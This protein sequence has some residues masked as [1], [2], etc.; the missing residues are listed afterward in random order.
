MTDPHHD[1]PIEESLDKE[2]SL[3]GLWIFGL[4]ILALI[5]AA[6]AVTWVVSVS[7]RSHLEAQDPPTP[8][9]IE[10]RWEHE[11]PGPRLQADPSAELELYNAAQEEMLSGYGWVDEAG[12]VARVPIDRAIDLALERGLGSSTAPIETE[13]EVPAE[14]E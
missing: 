12:G 4:G 3:K 11:P 13:T 2:L 1:R 7:L 6:G 8:A 14:A 5:G 9:L 10:A